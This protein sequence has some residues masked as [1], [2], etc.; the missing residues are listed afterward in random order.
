MVLFGSK[1][2][3]FHFTDIPELQGLT[4]LSIEVSMTFF[5]KDSSSPVNKIYVVYN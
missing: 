2:H 1:P 3:T 4:A 5:F